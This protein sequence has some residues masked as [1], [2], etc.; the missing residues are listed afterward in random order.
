MALR[1]YDLRLAHRVLF[2]LRE[3][4]SSGA[5]SVGDRGGRGQLGVASARAL[6]GVRGHAL[7]EVDVT[8]RAAADRGWHAFGDSNEGALQRASFFLGVLSGGDG[9]G[10]AA[11]DGLLCG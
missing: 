2:L 7:E 10:I 5:T 3:H 6:R 9:D 11:D 8:V 4:S 1:R